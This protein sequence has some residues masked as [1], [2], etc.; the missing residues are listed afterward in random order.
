M[1]KAIVL[2]QFGSADQLLLRELPI[3]EP[4]V[5]EIQIKI[6]YAGVN[7]VDWKIRQGL[8]KDRIP[9]E[10]P[11]IPGWDAAGVVSKV[12]KHATKFKAGDEVFAYCRKPI[13]KW[14]TYAE[15]ICYPALLVAFKPSI[16]SFAQAAAIPLAGL[17]AWQ[18]LFDFLHL[19]RGESILIHAGAGGV[20]S[21]A[22]QFA[23]YLGTF[24][25]TTASENNHPYVKRLGADVIVDYGKEN[26]VDRI[27]QVAPNG[28]DLVFDTVGGNTLSESFKVMKPGGRLVSI[29]QP[30]DQKMAET[31]QV[32]AGYVFVQPNGE[33]LQQIAELIQEG[34]VIPPEIKE[35]PLEKASQAQ[36]ENEQRHVQGKIVL[37]VS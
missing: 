19:K 13:I 1:M 18:A 16:L 17:T 21:L 14:G 15:Y 25:Y 33:Q 9:H 32:Q 3:P 37:K 28:I 10:F 35:L 26:F 5:D 27:R 20:G 30:P 6:A 22:I 4:E 8:L 2:E 31:F 29:V 7:P 12:G 23:K 24:V 36:Q 11:L 34:H